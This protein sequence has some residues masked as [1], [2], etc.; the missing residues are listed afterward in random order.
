MGGPHS[1][2]GPSAAQTPG[3]PAATTGPLRS[4]ACLCSD[5]RPCRAPS[6]DAPGPRLGPPP[7]APHAA[8][9]GAAGGVRESHRTPPRG[10]PVGCD[11]HARFSCSEGR[12]LTTLVKRHSRRSGGTTGRGAG[13]QGRLLRRFAV[14]G[15]LGSAPSGQAAVQRGGAQGAA[16]AGSCSQR[17]ARARGPPNPLGGSLAED[18]PVA[19]CR[20][21]SGGDDEPVSHQGLWTLG[22]RAWGWGCSD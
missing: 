1:A 7:P 9:A 11:S 6:E 12:I 13:A 10:A 18:G 20:L 2:G 17:T 8:G 21:G 14:R 15:R 22:D 5:R 4:P 3:G 16:A 19:R